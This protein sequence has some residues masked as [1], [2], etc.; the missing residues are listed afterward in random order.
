MDWHSIAFYSASM[1]SAEQNY[2]IHD[3]EMLAIIRALQEWRPELEG[4]RQVGPF[5][6]ITDHRALQ[7]FMTSKKLNARQAR[8]AEFL[9]RFDFQI[10]YRPGKENTLADAL[11][12]PEALNKADQTQT[13]LKADR[14]AEGIEIAPLDSAVHI[15]DRVVE[16]NQKSSSLERYREKADEGNSSYTLRDN[17]LLYKGR[18]VVPVEADETLPAQLIKEAHAQVSTAHPGQRKTRELIRSRY[19]WPI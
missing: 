8:W 13:L 2:E 14:L 10:Q 11:S 4:I 5:E 3:K 6:V 1:N 9:S 19:W 15:V 18:L 12:R 16:L 17:L 7:Y